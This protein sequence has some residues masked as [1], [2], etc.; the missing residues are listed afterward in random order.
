MAADRLSAGG[1]TQTIMTGRG[2]SA[3]GTPGSIRLLWVFPRRERR[4]GGALT[5]QGRTTTPSTRRTM[6]SGFA[7]FRASG[8]RLSGTF[9]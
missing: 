3:G 8:S 6:R 7:S 4:A 5:T 1:E 9:W 2:V